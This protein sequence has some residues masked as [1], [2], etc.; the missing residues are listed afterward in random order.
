MSLLIDADFILYKNAAACETEVDFGSNVIVVSSRFSDLQ[1]AIQRDFDRIVQ[2]LQWPLNDDLILFFSDTKNFRKELY[3]DYKGHR[4]RKKPCGYQRA[5]NWLKGEFDVRIVPNIEADDALGIFQTEHAEADHI[6]VSPDKDMKQIPGRLFDPNNL[7]LT[8]I[9]PEYGSRWHLLQT[10]AGDPT[11]GYGGCPG[12]G[13]VKGEKL[14]DK[15]GE[16]WSTVVGAF[17]KA[18]LTEADALLNA[19]LAKILTAD[20]YEHTDSPES[21]FRLWTPDR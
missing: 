9:T 18:G 4:N 15:E 13:L 19:R 20:L 17:T 12:I 8:T 3:P 21:A 11:D 1:Y 14:L 2:A 7:T 6:I 5:I 16:N 10:L